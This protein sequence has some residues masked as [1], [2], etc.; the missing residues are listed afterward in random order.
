MTIVIPFPDAPAAMLP[1]END[2]P[3]GIDGGR[4]GPSIRLAEPPPETED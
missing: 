3:I 2:A 1:V 4:P